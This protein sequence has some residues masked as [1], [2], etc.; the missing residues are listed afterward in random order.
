M[1]S[2]E[3]APL[4]HEV[5]PLTKLMLR[6]LAI[7]TAVIVL[8]TLILSFVKASQDSMNYLIVVNMLISSIIGGIITWWYHKGIIEAKKIA[9]MA[10]VGICIIFQ[11]IISDVYVYKKVETQAP[12]VIAPTPATLHPSSI[13]PPTP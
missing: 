12:T 10:F 9:F 4:Y 11:A 6:A 2:T 7:V 3:A 1:D 5:S 8:I 13:V